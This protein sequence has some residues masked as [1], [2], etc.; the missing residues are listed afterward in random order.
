M[1]EAP[2]HDRAHALLHRAVLDVHAVDAGEA[3]GALHTAI[4]EVVVRAVLARAEGRLIDVERTVAEAALEAI[5]VRQRLRG[6]VLP[7]VDHR[8]L[9]IHR[10]PDVAGD[11]R[12]VTH[13]RAAG[14]NL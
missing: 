4:Q 14:T 1:L 6:A 11:A 10:Y 8:G 12:V 5:L 7:V 13:A 2:I 9:V 3:L